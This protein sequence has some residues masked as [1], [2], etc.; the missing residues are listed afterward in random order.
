MMYYQYNS[1]PSQPLRSDTEGSAVDHTT[2]TTVLETKPQQRL[3]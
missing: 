2:G 1:N 3:I